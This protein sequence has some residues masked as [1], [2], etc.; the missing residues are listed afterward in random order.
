MKD[1][2][3]EKNIK[4]YEKHQQWKKCNLVGRCN[5]KQYGDNDMN[6]QHKEIQVVDALDKVDDQTNWHHRYRSSQAI[7]NI[8]NLI[9]IDFSLWGVLKYYTT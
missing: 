4:D 1:I 6:K 8:K 7:F 2:F 3:K 5:A 9:M